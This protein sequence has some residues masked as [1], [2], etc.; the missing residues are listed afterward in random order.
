[1]NRLIGLAVLAVL[2][3]AL[4][5]IYDTS[6]DLEQRHGVAAGSAAPQVDEAV[7]PATLESGPVAS[8]STSPSIETPGR[9]VV[10][11]VPRARVPRTVRVAGRVSIPPGAPPAPDLAV[12]VR[13]TAR[14][15]DFETRTSVDAWGR[16]SVDVPLSLLSVR[17]DLDARYLCLAIPQT[18][19]LRA[20]PDEL[21]LDAQVGGRLTVRLVPESDADPAAVR[22]VGVT[23]DS[24]HS[25]SQRARSSSG[26]AQRARLDAMRES[27]RSRARHSCGAPP[28]NRRPSYGSC[29]R[30]RGPS[31]PRGPCG[32]CPGRGS[33]RHRGP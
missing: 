9:E 29:G 15:N 6:P 3:V 23:L 4:W 18:L 12:V 1:M 24:G 27:R 8:A 5:A 13:A 20:M 28:L 22:N 17:I 7:A 21:V 26:D 19:A 16:F 33:C 10:H 32:R 30:G 2:I 14:S 25:P 11:D 31:S